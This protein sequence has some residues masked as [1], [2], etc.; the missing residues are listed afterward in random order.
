VFFGIFPI[1]PCFKPNARA[2]DQLLEKNSWNNKYRTEAA[3][4]NETYPKKIELKISFLVIK[5]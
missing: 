4:S 1:L 5:I 2:E 3:H